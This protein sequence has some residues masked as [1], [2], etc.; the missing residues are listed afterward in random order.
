MLTNFK[1]ENTEEKIETKT[2]EFCNIKK[3]NSHAS[4]IFDLKCGICTGYDKACPAYSSK[5]NYEEMDSLYT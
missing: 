2:E 5:K 3:A 4:I 1:M